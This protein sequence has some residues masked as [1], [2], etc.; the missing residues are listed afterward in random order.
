MC[1]LAT[2]RGLLATLAPMRHSTTRC[3]S[4]RSNMP[5][6]TFATIVALSKRSAKVESRSRP[7]TEPATIQRFR[8]CRGDVETGGC[9][10]GLP[11]ALSSRAGMRKERSSPA[12]CERIHPSARKVTADKSLYLPRRGHRP[13]NAGDGGDK[14]QL[15]C[16]VRHELLNV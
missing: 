7:K 3:A 5:T 10:A 15:T 1:D 9:P 13:P 11:G 12:A 8:L 14:I 4:S 2:R 16:L 6:R